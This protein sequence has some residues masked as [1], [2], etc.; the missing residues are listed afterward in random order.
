MRHTGIASPSLLV[1]RFSRSIT[2][3]FDCIGLAQWLQFGCNFGRTT[4]SYPNWMA[5][6]RSINDSQPSGLTTYGLPHGKYVESP[7]DEKPGGCGFPAWE[8]MSLA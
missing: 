7:L 6:F 2:L 8:L 5:R 1:R 3:A 4:H